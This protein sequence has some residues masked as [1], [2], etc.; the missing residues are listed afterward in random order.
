[1]GRVTYLHHYL[2][3]L[4]FAVLNLGFMLDHFILSN[5]YFAERTRAIA[6]VVCASAIVGVVSSAFPFTY[7]D[8]LL[9]SRILFT[10]VVVQND[11]LGN[12]RTR[13]QRSQ[14]EENLEYVQLKSAQSA[15]LDVLNE[16]IKPSRICAGSG[17]ESAMKHQRSAVL[18]EYH[19]RSSS[20]STIALEKNGVSEENANNTVCLFVSKHSRT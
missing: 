1:M 17:Y 11:S 15:D 20:I 12:G 9:S 2:P 7:I 5:K 10:V 19:P 13:S 16:I 6:F 14:M 8:Q 18:M 3:C 4:I